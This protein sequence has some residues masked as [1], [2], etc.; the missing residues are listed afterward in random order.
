MKLCKKYS[1]DGHSNAA[2]RLFKNCK[3]PD[4]VINI[5]KGKIQRLLEL[6]SNALIYYNS[7][8]SI[9]LLKK[10]QNNEYEIQKRLLKHLIIEKTI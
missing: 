9:N 8:I 2:N 4:N 5:P 1:Q 6:I 7:Q 3:L 10:Q